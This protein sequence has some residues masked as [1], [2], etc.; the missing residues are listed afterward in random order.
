M[1]AIILA[2]GFGSRLMPLTQ[3]NPKCMVEYKGRKLID[4]EISALK[5][6]GISEI[7]VVGGYLF[8]V[9]K[10]YVESQF[11]IKKI[12][13]N[14]NFDKTNMVQT[15]FC[16]RGFLESCVRE[17][18]D[19]V[20][21]YADIVYGAET[22]RTLVESQAPLAIVVDKDW[23]S[24]WEKRF[25][26]PLDDAETLKI[27][28]GKIKELGKKPKSYEEIEGQYI[29][30]FKFSYEFLPKVLEFYDRLDRNALYDG[31]DFNNM[32][33]TSFLQGLIDE[34][35]NAKAVEIKGGW[36]EIDFK[37]DL[38]IEIAKFTL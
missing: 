32:Y 19:L 20:I 37:S 4:Y 15:L 21:S 23:R 26:N 6:A 29:G 11:K 1:K 30:L 27:Q 18:Q 36:C 10:Q 16:A 35:D 5:E 13:Q 22:A 2:A 17:K 12:Y 7:A 31:K 25:E 33:M 14:T 24:L 34:F 38:E 9:L 28:E 8:E 3:N